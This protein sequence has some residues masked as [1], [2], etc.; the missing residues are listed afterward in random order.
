MPAPPPTDHERFMRLFLVHEPEILR[1]VLLFVPQRADARDIVQDT[2]V[3]LWQHFSEYDPARPFVHW[4][5]GF[6]RIQV[7]RFLRSAH[8]RA[9]LSER[10]AEVLI[11]AEEVP[12]AC[13]ERRDAALRE[14]LGQ[15]APRQHEIIAGY[16]FHERSVE[17]LAREHGCSI[18]ALYKALQRIRQALLECISRKLA[19]APL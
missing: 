15:L 14:C 9:A 2:A 6:A 13:Q 16:Y 4:A 17:T 11:G 18:E 3:A 12:G 5:V 19:E 8:R 7:R 10:A 1:S